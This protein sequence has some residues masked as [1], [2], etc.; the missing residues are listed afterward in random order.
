MLKSFLACILWGIYCNKITQHKNSRRE[1]HCNNKKWRIKM[2]AHC[3]LGNGYL[4]QGQRVWPAAL[5]HTCQGKPGSSPGMRVSSKWEEENLSDRFP[6]QCQGAGVSAPQPS[7]QLWE[8]AP[9]G[10]SRGQRW[11][12]S[13]LIFVLRC[14]FKGHFKIRSI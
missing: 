13:H 14:A 10:D 11:Q 2:P 5:S 8:A 12:A 1:R 3:I 6:A 9:C 7:A 4:S